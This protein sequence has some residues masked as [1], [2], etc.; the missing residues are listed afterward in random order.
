MS[1]S[2]SLSEQLAMIRTRLSFERTE[3]AEDKSIGV[4]KKSAV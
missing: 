2:L 4:G 3:L 1:E